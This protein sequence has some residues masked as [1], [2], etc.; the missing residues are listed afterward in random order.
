MVQGN[1]RFTL[2]MPRLYT[3]EYSDL[4]MLDRTLYRQISFSTFVGAIL[5][6]FPHLLDIKLYVSVLCGPI[7]PVHC[8]GMVLTSAFAATVLIRFADFFFEP[9]A[10]ASNFNVSSTGREISP[11]I[12]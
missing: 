1:C 3:T 11:G 8:R 6:L 9:C 5:F 2:V 4:H 7:A 10:L 12:V